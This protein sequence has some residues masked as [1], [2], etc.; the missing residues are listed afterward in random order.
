MRPFARI[1][2]DEP[3]LPEVSWCWR[4]TWSTELDSIYGMLSKFAV[5][6]AIGVKEL[7][8]L[9]IRNDLG[10]KKATQMDPY[11]DLR[12]V[13]PFDV[14]RIAQEFR[15]SEKAVLGGFVLE[16]FPN[17][18]AKALT[19]LKWCERCMCHGLH[20]PFHQLDYIGACP[21]HGVSLTRGCPKCKSQIPY[22]LSRDVFR[23]PFACPK[24]GY[25]LAGAI[26][27][28]AERS[29]QLSDD[30][31]NRIEDINRILTE[32][33]RVV[34]LAYEFDRE[35]RVSGCSRFAVGRVDVLKSHLDYTGFVAAVMDHLKIDHSS[36]IP[37]ALEGIN[38]VTRGIPV[39]LIDVKNE[40][41]RRRRWVKAPPRA[42]PLQW[43][44]RL[45]QLEVVYRAVR[46]HLWRKVL[47][48]HRRCVDSACRTLWWDLNGETTADFCSQAIAF[49]R[50]RMYWEGLAAPSDLFREPKRRPNGLVAWNQASVSII[51]Y[52]WSDEGAHWVM[53]HAFAV[54]LFA[55]FYQCLDDAVIART[56]GKVNWERLDFS[57]GAGSHWAISGNDSKRFPLTFFSDARAQADRRNLNY[58]SEGP[59]EHFRWHLDRVAKIMR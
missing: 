18:Q 14:R 46:R 22:R 30:Q 15:S 36:Q 8:D 54:S 41:R 51:R 20:I 44:T 57:D 28:Q 53:Q 9:F 34:T 12:V 3:M 42:D 45:D 47:R 2:L 43:T 11:I 23:S 33:D 49:I 58:M 17:A 50:W 7:V 19:D 31:R 37:L 29:I 21:V 40:I 27:R 10:V 1:V 32:E 25:E 4:D 55:R 6:N 59:A 5:L 24:C 48:W 35:S 26:K 52:N 38:A 16:R 39:T 56:T 13:G